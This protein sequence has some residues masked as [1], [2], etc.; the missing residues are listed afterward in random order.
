MWEGSCGLFTSKLSRSGLASLPSLPTVRL[1]P[2][3]VSGGVL[4]PGLVRQE[5]DRNRNRNRWNTGDL[6]GNRK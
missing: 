1:E 6:P 3:A 5:G 2:G 4:Q